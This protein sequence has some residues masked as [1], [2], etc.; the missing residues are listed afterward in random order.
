MN[1]FD[2]YVAGIGAS[3]GGINAI[4][5]FF[6][7]IPGDS[8]ICFVVILHFPT[9]Y[10][11]KFDQILSRYTPLP[12][13]KLNQTMPAHPNHV[14]VLPGCFKVTMSDNYLHIR[15]RTH[16]EIINT[17]ID[18]FLISLAKTKKEKSIG[19]ILSGGGMDGANGIVEIHKS[20]GIVLVQEP[21]S[22]DYASMP[23]A[24]IDIDHPDE[25]STPSE[26]SLQLLDLVKQK[27]NAK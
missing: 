18:E 25:I 3:A 22:A 27:S 13:L 11:T 15:K 10:D 21:A 14:Y 17:A 20:H 12:V 9:D 8:G 26:L 19:V 5:N 23:A 6:Q 7:N 24:A 2:F 4:C 1:N 16:K